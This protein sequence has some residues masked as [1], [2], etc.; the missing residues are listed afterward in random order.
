MSLVSQEST[1]SLYGPALDGAC[2][3]QS[4]SQYEEGTYDA[5]GRYDRYAAPRMVDGGVVEGLEVDA[6][7]DNADELT[8]DAETPA[9]SFYDSDDDRHTD[10]IA[11][12]P[13]GNMV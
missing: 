3:M 8:S 13:T 1:G 12:S 9:S 4:I 5:E 6:A 7:L 10:V 11:W 2:Q